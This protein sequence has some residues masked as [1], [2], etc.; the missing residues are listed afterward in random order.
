MSSC[1]NSGY[2]TNEDDWKTDVFQEL[3]VFNDNKI[4]K[5]ARRNIVSLD[6]G[7]ID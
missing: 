3:Y 4:I 5:I 2:E 6:V 7:I 1:I